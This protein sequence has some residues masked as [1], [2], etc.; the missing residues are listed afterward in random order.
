MTFTPTE[1]QIEAA[2]KALW[3]QAR[4]AEYNAFCETVSLS[5]GRPKTMWQKRLR[6]T[7]LAQHCLPPRLL[8]IK[9]VL[10]ITISDIYEDDVEGRDRTVTVCGLRLRWPFPVVAMLN[11][12]AAIVFGCPV[13]GGKKRRWVKSV[14]RVFT[15]ISDAKYW[16]LNRA[17]PRYR[18]HVV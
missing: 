13:Y 7:W 8:R 9:R 12:S 2:A 17:H 15:R 11:S 14:H 10:L 4:S 18:F 3:E 5:H 6:A 1:K 16:V